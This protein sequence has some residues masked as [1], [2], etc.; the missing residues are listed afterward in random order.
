MCRV[1]QAS[2]C[3]CMCVTGWGKAVTLFALLNHCTVYID[4]ANV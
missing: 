1:A 2:E 3:T 4:I